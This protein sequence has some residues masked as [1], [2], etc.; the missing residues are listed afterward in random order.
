MKSRRPKIFWQKNPIIA[1]IEHGGLLAGAL[2]RRSKA[3]CQWGNE[4]RSKEKTYAQLYNVLH[5][6]DDFT[7]ARL[8]TTTRA[9]DWW[10]PCA[11]VRTGKLV[12]RRQQ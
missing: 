1:Q 8:G 12:A 10:V 6:F 4:S 2:E 9:H 11:S 7:I 5:A 3:C